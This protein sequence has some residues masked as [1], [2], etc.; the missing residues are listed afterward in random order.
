MEAAGL[1]DFFDGTNAK[2]NFE[3]GRMALATMGEAAV[4]KSDSQ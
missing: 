3:S 1:T 4:M 2:I